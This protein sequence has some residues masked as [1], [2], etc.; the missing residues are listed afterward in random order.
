MGLE[1]VK[2]EVLVNAQSKAKALL[3]EARSEAKKAESEALE[4]VKKKE[5]LGEQETNSYIN[6]VRKKE[7]SSAQLEAK[8][9]MLNTKKQLIDSV[10]EAVIGRLDKLESGKNRS[11]LEKLLRKA[12]DEINVASVYVNKKHIKLMEGKV[13]SVQEAVILGGLIAE[14]KDRTVRVD[15]SFDSLLNEVKEKSLGEI[16]GILFGKNGSKK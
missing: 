13:P 3:D 8:N 10:F 7:L 15:Y 9:A 11:M 5:K 14:N 1:E 16:G 4:A 2:K 12:Q 6:G